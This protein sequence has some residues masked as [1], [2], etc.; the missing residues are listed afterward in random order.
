[1]SQLYYQAKSVKLLNENWD[2]GAF[3]WQSQRKNILNT[4]KGLNLE[5]KNFVKRQALCEASKDSQSAAL[6]IVDICFTNVDL[7]IEMKDAMDSAPEAAIKKC[8]YG[9]MHDAIAQKELVGDR[10]TPD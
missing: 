1:M 5:Q 3:D 9:H 10:T 6:D 7:L 4:I 2:D 8:M